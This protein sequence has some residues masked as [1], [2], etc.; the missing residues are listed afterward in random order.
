MTPVAIFLA[1][2]G[3]QLD[4]SDGVLGER[5]SAR[6]PGRAQTPG[7]LSAPFRLR[8]ALGF[9]GTLLMQRHQV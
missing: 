6:S 9:S 1:E 8:F 2:T 4:S 3:R 7:C 5:T